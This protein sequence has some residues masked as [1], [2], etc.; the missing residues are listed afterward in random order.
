MKDNHKENLNTKRRKKGKRIGKWVKQIRVLLEKGKHGLG[1]ARKSKLGP[2]RDQE[3]WG[4]S[5]QEAWKTLRHEQGMRRKR[6]GGIFEK[7]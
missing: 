7:T 1:E 5:H 4:K 3:A 2:E 6:R